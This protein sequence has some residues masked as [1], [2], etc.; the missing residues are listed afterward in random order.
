MYGTRCVRLQH[1][2]LCHQYVTLS[3][4]WGN[5]R[6]YNASSIQAWKIPCWLVS[7]VQPRSDLSFLLYSI[8]HS[9]SCR[10]ILT[11]CILSFLHIPFGIW[12]STGGSKLHAKGPQHFPIEPAT[13]EANWGYSPRLGCFSLQ[14]H[15]ETV[16]SR[17]ATAQNAVSVHQ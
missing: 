15:E 11:E 6:G 7:V 8:P 2:T 17:C 5:V 10:P 16:P 12:R 1:H 9:I 14:K 13:R 4:G 3:V